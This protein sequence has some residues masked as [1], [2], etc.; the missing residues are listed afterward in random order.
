MKI[1]SKKTALNY[2][3]IKLFGLT[4]YKKERKNNAVIKKYVK[5]LF[6]TKKENCAI[7]YYVMGIQ[8]YV[9]EDTIAKIK[10]L[11]DMQFQRSQKALATFALHQKTFG[12]YKNKFL[13]KTVALYGAGPSLTYFEP[14]KNVINVGVNRVFLYDKVKFDFLFAIDKLSIEEYYSELINYDCIKFIGNQ[15]CGKNW[16]IPENIIARMEC[17]QYNTT[18]RMFIENKFTYNIDCEP[19]CNFRTVSL[20]AI[21]FILYTNP[22]RIYII[23]NDCTCSSKEHFLGSSY[24]IS[25]RGEDIVDNDINIIKGWTQLKD[26]VEIYYPD[27][28]I[29]SVNPV[30]LKGLF[31][32][33]YTKNY[34]KDNPQ[35]VKENPNITY[36]DEIENKET[37]L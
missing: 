37:V 13:S 34:I 7:K 15:D 16:Q 12:P 36:L 32:D 31:K 33:V 30:G 19:I 26:F 1:F 10:K 22:K 6:K 11:L 14:I 23:G 35:I 17:S 9:K 18:S 20:Q 29:I 24:D 5:G 21:Q 3:K 28:E 2:K 27:T 4:L 8:F 25:F